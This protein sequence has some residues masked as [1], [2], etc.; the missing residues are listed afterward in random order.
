METLNDKIKKAIGLTIFWTWATLT[1]GTVGF[2][3]YTVGQASRQSYVNNTSQTS[4]T[5]ETS[6]LEGTIVGVLPSSICY[7]IGYQSTY[8]SAKRKQ[9]PTEVKLISLVQVRTSD[10]NTHNLVHPDP[11]LTTPIRQGSARLIY[12][13][14]DSVSVGELISKFAPPHSL[15]CRPYSIHASGIIKPNGIKY[16]P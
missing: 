3:V 4:K 15:P 14:R 1:V 10:G 16:L 12:E 5:E 7:E 8:S 13:K 11:N 6:E 9:L 2:G